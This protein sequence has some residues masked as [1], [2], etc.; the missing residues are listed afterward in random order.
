MSC[1]LFLDFDG[2]AHPVNC[3][4]SKLFCCLPL[5]EGVLRGQG[6]VDIVISSSW[7]ARR[8]IEELKAVFSPD[9]RDRVVGV[10]PMIENLGQRWAIG[11]FPPYERQWEVQQ[12]MRLHATWD[13][14]WI[15][16]DDQ[17]VLFEPNC[18][19]LLVTRPETGFTVGQA[20]VLNSMIDQS[21]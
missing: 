15:A 3:T 13:T 19:H 16:I 20:E 4:F 11:Q 21:A 8:G 2:A 12:W 5:I 17:P 9:M 18:S 10:T 6:H 14:P 7:R 1:V